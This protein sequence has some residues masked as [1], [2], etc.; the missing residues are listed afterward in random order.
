MSAGYRSGFAE[1]Y[2]RLNAGVDYGEIADIAEGYARRAGRE[3]GLWLDL[4]C[5]TGSLAS[6]L[7]RRGHEVIGADG[8]PEMLAQAAEKN[9]GLP[10]PVLY[11]CQEM[12]ALDL[13]GTV[14]AAC[15][16][17]DSLNHLSGHAALER[18]L[19]RLRLFVEPGGVLVFDMNTPKK[20]RETLGDNA[21]V[22]ERDGLFCAWQN[23]CAPE[24]GRVDIAIDCF[25]REPGGL[26][27]RQGDAFSEFAEAPEITEAALASHGFALLE[28]R[29][30]YSFDAPGDRTVFA[31]RRV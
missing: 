1:L 20:H 15:C 2:D 11:L 19:E 26:W 29:E 7:A 30:G 9:A 31:A 23:A 17:M 13:Y 21:F 14:S 5:G 22:F 28:R 24:E 18:V 10:R 3:T 16:T 27:R 6:E 25:C 12:E 4:A 8:S